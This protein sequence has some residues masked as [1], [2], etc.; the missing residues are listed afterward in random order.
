MPGRE[1]GYPHLPMELSMWS[2]KICCFQSGSQELVTTLRLLTLP[3]RFSSEFLNSNSD[4][5][6]SESPAARLSTSLS[7]TAVAARIHGAYHCAE[8]SVAASLGKLALMQGP[9]ERQGETSPLAAGNCVQHQFLD[10]A[11]GGGDP[12][13]LRI[14]SRLR[15][16]K[17]GA[18]GGRTRGRP[19]LG[20]TTDNAHPVDLPHLA[21]H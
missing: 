15:L 16:A 12:T 9:T 8:S 11:T 13:I 18:H 17:D 6:G 4:C 5:C 19:W 3:S 20:S 1:V 14:S 10:S 2:G 7:R 21:R